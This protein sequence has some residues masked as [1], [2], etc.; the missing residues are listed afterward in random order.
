MKSDVFRKGSRHDTPR[1]AQRSDDLSA[2][3]PASPA[4]CLQQ[5]ELHFDPFL[6]LSSDSHMEPVPAM[7]PQSIKRG[8]SSTIPSLPLQNLTTNFEDVSSRLRSD[9]GGNGLLKGP[10]LRHPAVKS[11]S[12]LQARENREEL[13][14][15]D[16]QSPCLDDG[17][18]PQVE[19]GLQISLVSLRTHTSM[20]RTY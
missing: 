8:E 18:S 4:N 15:P 16:D 13:D 7:R 17:P 9:V 6:K 2:S 12:L 3:H 14:P 1:S 11:A 10:L 5:S 19:A 20:V